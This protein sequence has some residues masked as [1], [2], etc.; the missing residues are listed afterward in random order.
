ML[1]R[2]SSKFGKDRKRENGETNGISNGVNGHSGTSN[3]STASQKATTNGVRRSS[4]FG[5]S[6]HEKKGGDVER[7]DID[8][9]FQEFAQLIHASKRPMPNQNGDGT[10]NG[11]SKILQW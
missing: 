5:F 4:T 6:K 11:T 10:Y 7:K 9:M 2:L 8:G 1:R 3:G